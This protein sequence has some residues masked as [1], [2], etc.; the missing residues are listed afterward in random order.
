MLPYAH[1]GA[2]LKE[3]CLRL[4]PLLP[5]L[6]LIGCNARWEFLDSGFAGGAPEV[7]LTE[8]SLGSL[9]SIDSDITVRAIISDDVDDPSA[10]VLE[11]RSDVEGVVAQPPVPPNGMLDTTIT[12]LPGTHVFTLAVIDSDGHEGSDSTTIV[13]LDG[14]FP[15]QPVV[16]IAPREPGEGDNLTAS[17]LVESTDPQGDPLT[18]VWSWTVDDV[19]AGIDT[20]DVDGAVAAE[21]QV[22]T[23]TV[24]ATDGTSTSPSSSRSV[25]VGPANGSETIVT[26]LPESPVTGTV[27]TCDHDPLVDDAG[28]SVPIVYD[29]T[30]DGA[31]AGVATAT[32]DGDRVA[33][34]QLIGCGVSPEDGAGVRYASGAVRIGNAAPTAA[35]PTLR[36]AVANESSTLT[37]TP[38]AT[39]DPEGD[40]VTVATRWRIAGSEVGTGGTLTGSAFNKGDSVTCEVTPADPFAAGAP[41]ESAPLTIG[42]SAPSAPTVAFTS[43]FVVPGVTAECTIVTDGSDADGDVLSY[44]WSWSVNGVAAVGSSPSFATTGRLQGDTLTCSATPDDGTASGPAGS[45]DLVL[46]GSTRGDQTVA[47]AWLVISGTSSSGGLG[48]A[49][50]SVTDIDGDGNNELVVS[51]PRG[52]GGTKGSVYLYYST[53]LAAGI[54]LRDDDADAWWIGHASG[55]S[56]GAGRGAAGLGDFDGDGIGDVTAASPYES[57][58]GAS[59]G[60][61]Y[62][63]HGGDSWTP[64]G[65]IDTD[66]SA[67]F[68][69]SAGDW[70]GTR[71][72]GGDLNGDGI[73]DLVAS[74]PYDDL[75]AEKA[76]VLGVWYGQSARYSGDYDLSD[77]DALV[78]G[79]TAESGLGWSL[80]VIED[81]DGDGYEEVAVGILRDDTNASNAGSAAVIS[82]GDLGGRATYEAIAFLV[83]RGLGVEDRFGYDVAGAGDIDGDGLEDMLFGGYVADGAAGVDAGEVRLFYGVRGLN[84]EADADAA[85]ASFFG[86]GA[87][88]QFGSLLTGVGDYDADGLADF[89]V[90]APRS[91]ESGHSSSGT[92]YVYLGVDSGTWSAAGA[93]STIR[94]H[95]G[96]D[97]DWLSDE[98]CGG[99][100]LNGDRY[101][102]YALG[103]QLADT[104]TTGGGAVFLFTGP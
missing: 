7:Y 43:T 74:A 54:D 5:G 11:L 64:G 51:A 73:D 6:A 10:L 96:A 37:C 100:D 61:V 33:R 41:V 24:Y 78:T 17:L 30:V 92:G 55:D 77:A 104:R 81:A 65:D 35:I 84:T 32:L 40:L 102:D 15:T 69:G 56:L 52:D 9:W 20:P 57:T 16:D 26:V 58:T 89:V 101:A 62:V 59:A 70:L 90:G 31:D 72:A 3:S 47:D 28:T 36:P 42:N 71:L 75:E 60:T 2:A 88:D 66:A 80:D 79:V 34:G 83:V 82:G 38:G 53:T 1:E 45:A 4:I 29:W 21:G 23:A 85:D 97:D 63:L 13:V 18:Y 95:G 19:D 76:G 44:T 49:L 14:T 98:A 48:K 46:S 87:G 8:P 25:T 39:T 50:D 86:E 99:L 67:R 91:S 27:L 68:Q 93:V 94:V 103:A 22:W 12:L